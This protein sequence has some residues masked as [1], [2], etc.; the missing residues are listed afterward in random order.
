MARVAEMS[1]RGVD[2]CLVCDYL[3]PGLSILMKENLIN[4]MVYN[5]IQRESDSLYYRYA[6]TNRLYK[7]KYLT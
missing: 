1:E 6:R 4:T 3:Y 7:S 5:D 2:A